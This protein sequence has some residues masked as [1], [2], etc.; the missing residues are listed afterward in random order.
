MPT[1]QFT[2]RNVK[3]GGCISTIEN[4][5]RTLDG[6]NEVSVT[7]DGGLVKVS[8]ESLDRTRLAQKLAELGYPEA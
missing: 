4:G 7:I 1:E 6:V 2:V 5:L 3:C 8:G